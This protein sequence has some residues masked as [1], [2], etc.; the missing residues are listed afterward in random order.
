M[1]AHSASPTGWLSCPVPTKGRTCNSHKRYGVK[2]RHRLRRPGFPAASFLAKKEAADVRDQRIARQSVRKQHTSSGSPKAATQRMIKRCVP[3]MVAA[4]SR[5]PKTH[6][7]SGCT[8][9]CAQHNNNLRNTLLA[10]AKS[11][12]SR[13]HICSSMQD[14][15][16][17]RSRCASG[18]H[19]RRFGCRCAVTIPSSVSAMPA[20]PAG[21]IVSCRIRAA[22]T[23]V[24]TGTAYRNAVVCTGPRTPTA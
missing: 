5:H 14:R 4:A 10:S 8:R 13:H 15:V 7:A 22:K 11:G 2:N 24:M 18:P 1:G 16:S 3:G 19:S 23:T 21:A 9:A 17:K 20:Y 6:P 12:E